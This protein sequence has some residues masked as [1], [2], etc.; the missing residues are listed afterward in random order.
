MFEG[1]KIIGA[2]LEKLAIGNF[3]WNYLMRKL[4]FVIFEASVLQK[5]LAH[6]QLLRVIILEVTKLF[7]YKLFQ[8]VTIFC[9]ELIL[10]LKIHLK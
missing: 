9:L 3:K 7:S 1:A 6:F 5:V 10:K 2:I 8:V 4:T